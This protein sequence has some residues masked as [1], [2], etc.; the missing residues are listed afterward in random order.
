MNLPVRKNHD[1]IVKRLG[2]LGDFLLALPMVFF[3]VMHL[4]HGRG[5][6]QIVP[7]WMPWRL[8]WAYFTGA[9][10]VA[11][12]TSIMARK[13]TR[14]AATLLGAMLLLFVFLIHLPNMVLSIAHHPGDFNVLWSYNGTGG[15]NNALK[16][17]ALSTSA[18]ILAAAPTDTE[19]NSPSPGVI[20]L[21]AIFA[22]I[23]ALYGLEHLVYRGFT[24]GIPSWT[25]VS[26][27]IPWR[28]F[29]G[30]VTGI[31]L[32]S[33]GVCILIKKEARAAAV[34][35]GLMILVVAV[36]T[37]VFRAVGDQ[38]NI[39]ELMN[40]AKDIGIAGG[41]LILSGKLPKGNESS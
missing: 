2:R 7:S 31:A 21:G 32:L 16:D 20:A 30:Y 25:L 5:V 40:T 22:A 36:C 13:H 9:A 28:R 12:G 24:P 8:F 27:W 37:Y 11:A 6:A 3:G 15:V 33:A 14:L 26:F 17:L 1:K 18:L 39:G 29:W 23:M 10:L 35:L 41:A 38:G 34:V 19:L 4:T